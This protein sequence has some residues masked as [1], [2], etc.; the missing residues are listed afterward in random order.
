LKVND[1]Y[2]LAAV[3][4]NMIDIIWDKVEPVLDRVVKVSNR[5]LTLDGIKGRCINGKNL[6]VTVCAGKEIIAVV[7]LDVVEFESGLRALYIPVVGGENMNEWLADSFEV[8]KAIAKDFNCTEVRGLSVRKG[9]MR[10]LTKMNW[11][12]ITTVISCP[13]E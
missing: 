8:A 1:K 12:V 13:V 11:Q 6:L 5:E 2:S 10:V 9:W 3:P 7:V 4:A